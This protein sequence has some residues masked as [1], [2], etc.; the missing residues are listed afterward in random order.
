MKSVYGEQPKRHEASGAG[1][2]ELAWRRERKRAGLPADGG[3]VKSVY[4]EQPKRHEASGA[5]EVEF[6]IFFSKLLL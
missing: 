2:V 3:F 1:E 4:G 6:G 5:G